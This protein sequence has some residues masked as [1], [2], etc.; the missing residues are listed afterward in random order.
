MSPGR[1]ALAL[2]ALLAALA[3]AA[4]VAA[5]PQI[6]VEPA[7]ATWREPITLALSGLVTPSCAVVV[8]RLDIAHD[9][10]EIQV[11]AEEVCP[12]G[13]AGTPQPYT[14]RRELGRL[15]DGERWEVR[16]DFDG[17]LRSHEFIVY[18]S[19]TLALAVPDR[20]VAGEPFEVEV[21]GLA[22][23]GHSSASLGD[24][25]AGVVEIDFTAICLPITNPPGRYTAHTVEVPALPPGDHELRLF[26]RDD[27]GFALQR[28]TLRVWPVAGCVPGDASLCLQGGRF[29]VSATWRDFA[30]ATGGGH[31]APLP[32]N[33][34][35]GLLWFF[36]PDNAEV[37]AKLI[38]GCA[39]NGHWWVFVTPA[40][41]VEHE[42]HVL[43][44]A[45]GESRTY[46]HESGGIPALL[47][48]TRAFAC[49][50]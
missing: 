41:T 36:T 22:P 44:T 20:V 1:R 18:D 14:L 5:P 24:V 9:V 38:D 43:D 7:L 13:A 16:L 19:G 15:A 46:R 49:G 26:T 8:R 50:A 42:V 47:A 3:P 21:R 12:P 25:A 23:C 4:A 39:Y 35:T 31:A 33:D 28:S 17:A 45:T 6:S 37:T 48:D 30:G 29:A 10:R 34:T 32:G 40:S 11:Q 27:F 2:H